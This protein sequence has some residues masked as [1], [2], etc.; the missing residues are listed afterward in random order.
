[1]S[2]RGWVLF[3][4]MSAIWGVPYLLI[5]V[6]VAEL[7][8]PVVVAGRTGIAA[9]VLIPLAAHRGALRPLLTVW[10]PLLAFTALEMGVPWLLLTDAERHLPSGLTGLLVAAVPLVGTLVAYLLGDHHA[11]HPVRLAGLAVGLGGVA[12]LVGAG[13][14]G[15]PVPLVSVVEVLLVAIGYASAPFILSRALKDVPWIGVAAASLGI[16]F[17]A[18]LPLAIATRPEVAPSASAGW[19]VLGL[20]VLCTGIAF[21]VFFALIDEVGPDRATLITFLNPAVAVLLGIVVLHETLTTGIMLGFPLVLVGCWLATR[22]P[23]ALEPLAP[24]ASH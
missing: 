9:A 24:V 11:L 18:Y 14:D 17:V 15:G 23:P 12:L 8:P 16:V 20:G 22:K 21:V 7:A 4:T 5:K 2:R 10:K 3:L 19:A 13:G 1:M 6:A